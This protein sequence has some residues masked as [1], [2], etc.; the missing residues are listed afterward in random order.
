MSQEN[1][2]KEARTR[3]SQ[4]GP[5]W[6]QIVVG[7]AIGIIIG[8]GSTLLLME[9]RVSKLEGRFEERDLDPTSVHRE[10]DINPEKLIS[11]IQQQQLANVKKSY[12]TLA[13][14]CFTDEDL[15]RFIR[16]KTTNRIASRLKK[17]PQF[18]DV[19]LAIRNM[20]PGDRSQLLISAEKP[21]RPTW[22]ELGKIDPEGQTE[23]GQQAELKIASA[24]VDLVKELIRLPDDKFFALYDI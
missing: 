23:T 18:L 24:I 1:A 21:L 6:G 13:H 11:I 8:V 7:V 22:G 9:R 20:Q 3:R 12:G 2:P 14:Q 10:T 19:V 15:E 5:N 4:T 17:D 16:A